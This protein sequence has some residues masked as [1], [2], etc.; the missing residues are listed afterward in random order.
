VATNAW[1]AWFSEIA[2][3]LAL[4]RKFQF[5][6]QYFSVA[7]I[8]NLIDQRKKK[9]VEKSWSIRNGMIKFLRNQRVFR[10]T[11]RSEVSRSNS[12]ENF[13]S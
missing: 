11:Q 5:F 4:L 10:S 9:E 13:A 2:N 3:V 7:E 12:S 6:D 1:Q 8:Y